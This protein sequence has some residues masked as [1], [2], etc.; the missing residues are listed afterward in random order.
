MFEHLASSFN[1]ENPLKESHE[2]GSLTD[3]TSLVQHNNNKSTDFKKIL[4]QFYEK[5]NPAK[6]GEVTK[7]LERYKGNEKEMFEKLAK[8]YNVPNPLHLS[9]QRLVTSSN[10][11]DFKAILI[12]FYQTHNP[13]KMGEIDKTLEK[14]KGHEEEMFEKLARKYS[15]P[16]PLSSTE[17]STTKTT[18]LT[19]KKI[20]TSPVKKEQNENNL[21]FGSTSSP[22]KSSFSGK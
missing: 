15:V 6:T 11:P 3:Q 2:I 17:Y 9:Q 19:D 10:S 1:A 21:L 22:N 14:Y 13:T 8:K 4:T 7:T 20:T 5:Y 12:G 16:N 18:I